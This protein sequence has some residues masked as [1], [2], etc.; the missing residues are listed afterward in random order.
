MALRKGLYRFDYLKNNFQINKWQFSP[1]VKKFFLLLGCFTFILVHTAIGQTDNFLKDFAERWETSRQYLMAV[2]E[3]MPESD[4]NYQPTP[5]EMS[6]ADQLMH[7]AWVIDW[8]CFSK[9]DGQEFRPRL[10]AFQ[11]EGL[12]KGEMM[13]I[14]DREFGRAAKLM[15]D[16][17]PGRLEEKGTYGKFTR[18]RRQFFLLMADHVTHHRGQ[19]IVYLR[20]MGIVPPPYTGFQ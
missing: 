17:D 11:S 4:Y 16:F 10:E 6:F 15:A 13:A 20:L 3:A 2:A 9:I 18:T 5:E 19:M 12:T 8:H 7:I 1:G 14:V